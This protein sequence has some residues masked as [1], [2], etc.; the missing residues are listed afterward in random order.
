[1]SDKLQ[2][3]RGRIDALDDQI[4]SLISERARCA[5]EV[6][7]I[8][9]DA[10]DDAQFYRPEREAQVL[11]R[12]Q[13]Q[14]QGPLADDEIARLFREIMSACLALEQPLKVAVL[15]PEGTFTHAAALKHFGHSV[16]VLPEKNIEAIFRAVESGAAQYGVVPVENST[17][18]AVN[19]SLDLFVG[20]P[21]QICGEVKL[22]IRCHLLGD[23]EK[24]LAA[25][26]HVYAHEQLLAQCRGWL[27]AHLPNAAQVAVSSNAEAARQIKGS[28][29]A[30]A[31]AGE[32]A[33]QR[34]ALKVLAES[35][36]DEAQNTTRFA[37]IGEQG[38]HASG[39]DKTS[40]LL[41]APNRPGALSRLLRPFERCGISLTRIE[42]RPSRRERWDYLFFI[43]IA[44]HVDDAKVAEA[45]AELGKESVMVKVLGS[46]PCAVL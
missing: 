35:I 39:C 33:V 41:S 24:D 20:S 9:H 12:I 22:R 18:G 3:V 2:Q 21:L 4:Q 45:L 5:V 31:I 40:L 29:H 43:D 27:A 15:G 34:Y 13:A 19:R 36:E 14:N 7:Q 1:L 10:G 17:E 37:I 44:G 23:S 8:K 26:T 25:V 30:V 38:T 6:A 46:Y 16:R 28:A 42:S 32:M 11:R